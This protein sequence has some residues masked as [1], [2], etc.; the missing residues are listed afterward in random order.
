MRVGTYKS[1]RASLKA[2]GFRSTSLFQHS[3]SGEV[4][5]AAG[6]LPVHHPVVDL[7]GQPY[8]RDHS[9][10]TVGAEAVPEVKN[11]KPDS[12]GEY[13]RC[14]RRLS[15]HET[16]IVPLPRTVNCRIPRCRGRS[17]V[18]EITLRA[19]LTRAGRKRSPRRG[20]QAVAWDSRAIRQELN[21]VYGGCSGSNPERRRR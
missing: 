16:T 21:L 17:R 5:S 11:E 14:R 7:I 13:Y 10:I 6:S 18:C 19:K 8:H 15:G 3:R 2:F 9:D 4:A 20:P 1:R 12:H